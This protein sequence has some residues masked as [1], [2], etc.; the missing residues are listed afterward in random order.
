MLEL[1]CPAGSLANLK[2]AIQKGADAVYL[3]MKKFSARDY[4]TN[5]NKEY[6]KQ[7]VK[8]CKSNDVKLYLAMNTLVKNHELKEY[9]GQL[10]YAYSEG[11][12]SVIIQDSSFID[13]IKKAYPDLN[14][15]ISTQAGVMNSAHANLFAK[16]D[17]ITLARELTKEEIARIRKNCK[18]E[19]E[20]F[21]HGA[22]CVSISGSCLFSS[23][24]GGRSG[25]RGKCAQPCR[26]RYNNK[27]LLSTK[28]LCLIDK[29]PEIA[30]LNLNAIKI[31]GRM[32]TP[33]YVATVTE[34]YRKAIDSYYEG[35]F[36][37]TA[38]M[39]KKLDDAFSR[40]FTQG[41]F[42]DS[43]DIFNMSKAGGRCNINQI[44]EEYKVAVKDIKIDRQKK[45]VNLSQ[46][47]KN[48]TKKQ[49]LVRVYNK[50][51]ALAAQDS[52]ADIIFCD[53]LNKNFMEI[54]GSLKCE[55]Y[56]VTPRIMLDNDL[57]KIKQAIE[58]KKPYGLLAGNP[59]ILSLNL[60]LPLYLD[61][62]LNCFNDISLS[63]YKDVPI[64]SPELSIN[65][66]KRF[67]N[68]EFAVLVHGRIRLMTLR[69][70][71]PA[72]VIR[73]EK[74]APFIVNPIYNG[75]EVLNNK[76]LGLLSKSSQLVSS[77]INRFF[78]DTDKEVATIVRL[79][80]QILDNK[81]VDDG[82]LKNRYVL[83][84]AYREVV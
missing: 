76:E 43:K 41:W 72:G 11:I 66:L 57:P 17:R 36:T 7:A 6:L 46:G 44:R 60:D 25:N 55:L 50:N 13:I 12:D 20:I 19:L 42:E 74:A 26:R 64:I 75:T 21:C 49:L 80:R 15:H 40:E 29:V 84:W 33:Y 27:Y 68:K 8:L 47:R 56:G 62:S 67:Q 78:I 52:G 81:K 22:L 71:L 73:D 82:K 24:I 9:F 35:N 5:F 59:G 39:R 54:K 10:S 69:H 16:A 23:F 31:E 79:Y 14:V 58:E 63:S 32:R 18:A 77:G 1:L 38:D 37:I 4:A 2:A 28:E 34:I 61:Y 45:E 83:G 3:G 70:N 53:L 51:D 48:S 30:K 65:E